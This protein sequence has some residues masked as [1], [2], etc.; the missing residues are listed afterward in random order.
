M[1]TALGIVLLLALCGFIAYIGDLLG[2]RLGKKRLTVFGLR[3]KHT[4]ILLTIVTGVLIAGVTFAAALISVPGFREV[5]TRGERLA[6]QNL[7]YERENRDL[8]SANA[9][10][11]LENRSRIE[12]SG[13]LTSA[14]ADLQKSNVELRRVS[15]E[16]GKTNTGLT[17]TNATLLARNANLETSSRQLQQR[18]EELRRSNAELVTRQRTLLT[19]QARLQR[20]VVAARDDV[21]SYRDRVQIFRKDEAVTGEVI[22]PN[23]PDAV[24]RQLV[25]NLVFQAETKTRA[26]ND[27][28]DASA[29]PIIWR[30]EDPGRGDPLTIADMEGAMVRQAHRH[31]DQYLVVRVVAHENCIAGRPAHMR[32]SIGP[33]VLVFRRGALITTKVIDGAESAGTILQ[34]LVNFLQSEVRPV[35]TSRPNWMTPR[36]GWI[37]EVNYDDLLP[38]MEQIKGINGYARVV[39]RAK[40]DTRTS[41]PLILDFDVLAVEPAVL[42]R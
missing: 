18:S 16:L 21:K 23:P 32:L 8:V 27:R 9:R 37:G 30:S 35:A 10:L 28:V 19:E 42:A 29:A 22:P 33:E 11:E 12:E 14:N 7:A 20:V 26:L 38:L 41:G 24:V 1:G 5:V 3:P 17:K 25:R 34:E 39:A 15:K 13:R 40:R 4:A 36:E 6:R 2:R 31:R